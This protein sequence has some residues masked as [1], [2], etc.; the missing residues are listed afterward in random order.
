MNVR[1]LLLSLSLSLLFIA[2]ESPLSEQ[3]ITDPGLIAPV[4][5]VQK[6]ISYKGTVY[7][8]YRCDI[9]DKLL[10][11]VELNNGSITVNGK[12]LMVIKDIV[13]SYYTLDDTQVPYALNSTYSFVITLSDNSTYN[14]MVTSHTDSLREF[15]V[16][17][18]QDTTQTMTVSWKGTVPGASMYLTIATS[19]KTPNGFGFSVHRKDIPSPAAGT[20]VLYPSDY[21]SGGGTTTSVDV[22]LHSEIDGTIDKRFY[23]AR[24]VFS[25]QF[26]TRTVAVR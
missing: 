16:P 2:C 10:R 22:T 24:R 12:K 1:T 26:I 11:S 4:L 25:H 8:R 13:G 18:E 15:V 19:Y 9:Y 14:G 7:Y 17:S 6:E 20:V 5:Q 3:N 21:L 23:S